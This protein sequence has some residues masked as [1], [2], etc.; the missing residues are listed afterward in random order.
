MRLGAPELCLWLTPA[1]WIET[2]SSARRCA[3]G[4][5]HV[6]H[7]ADPLGRGA[8]RRTRIWFSWASGTGAGSMTMTVVAPRVGRIR[9]PALQLAASAPHPRLFPVPGRTH[10]RWWWIGAEW[11][12]RPCGVGSVNPTLTLRS[13]Q[14][15]MIFSITL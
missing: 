2:A 6:V 7:L 8:N 14:V 1:T 3:F 11:C 13:R 10:V 4:E 5:A 12:R 15:P 9:S